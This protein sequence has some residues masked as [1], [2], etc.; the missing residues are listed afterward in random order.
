MKYLMLVMV[1]TFIIPAISQ[2]QQ[3]NASPDNKETL[4]EIGEYAFY[5]RGPNGDFVYEGLIQAI[6]DGKHICVIEAL[7]NERSLMRRVDM[8]ANNELGLSPLSASI[9]S[10]NIEVVKLLINIPGININNRDQA[11]GTTPLITASDLGK[12]EFVK[13]L[14]KVPGININARTIFRKSAL[15]SAAVEGH[16]EVVIELLQAPDINVHLRD[17]TGQT[18]LDIV[19]EMLL[20]YDSYELHSNPE[21]K[22]LYP[23][24]K[25][26]ATL[27]K[28]A[29]NN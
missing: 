16:L 13:E 25:Q 8:N 18:A 29:K 19:N 15:M 23:K 26:I 24:Y 27:L 12:T 11:L 14:L 28:V 1:T 17:V 21:Y 3:C 22:A 4:E 2:A 10:D 7:I 6:L 9:H 5:A 20:D